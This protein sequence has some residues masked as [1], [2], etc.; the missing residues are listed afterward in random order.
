[1]SHRQSILSTTYQAGGPVTLS[2]AIPG[3]EQAGCK[4]ILD[5]DVSQGSRKIRSIEISNSRPDFPRDGTFEVLVPEEATREGA[6]LRV[7]VLLQ[8]MNSPT[9]EFR[10]SGHQQGR[11]LFDNRFDGSFTF[12]RIETFDL[13]IVLV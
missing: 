4:A 9:F 1:M 5:V 12:G 3:D 8:K 2:F 6:L 11:V 13:D 7:T 10:I